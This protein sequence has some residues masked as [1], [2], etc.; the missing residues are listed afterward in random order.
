MSLGGASFSLEWRI[1]GAALPVRQMLVLKSASKDLNMQDLTQKICLVTG[2]TSGIGLATAKGLA[3][4]GARVVLVGRNAAKL[5]N[6][7]SQIKQEIGNQRIIGLLADLS[8]VDQVHDLARQFQ[9][10]SERLDVLVNNAGGFFLRRQLSV[11]GYEMTFALN[12]LSYFTLTILLLELMLDSA[13]ARIINVASETHRG[14]QLNLRDLHNKHR[15]TGFKAYGQSKLANLLFTYELARRLEG[16]QVT[17]NAMHPG[18]TATGIW[19][20]PAGWLKPL[21]SPLIRLIARSPEE[22]ADTVI[23]LA[24]SPEVS[25]VSG[26]YFF[27]RKTVPSDLA[28]YDESTARKVWDLS[29]RLARIE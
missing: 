2:A 11:D 5:E 28:S 22:G 6:T 10:Q 23:Y 19:H 3:E 17:V 12:H 18:F 16:T 1:P 27:N 21:I 14:Q 24:A 8:S 20:Q 26:K 15:Y 29:L 9:E 7:T 13:P 25:Q 4:L